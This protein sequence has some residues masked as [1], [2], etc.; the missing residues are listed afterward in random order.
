VGKCPSNFSLFQRFLNPFPVLRR[1]AAIPSPALG[2]QGTLLAGNTK[3]DS[4]ISFVMSI[5]ALLKSQDSFILF[6]PKKEH[7]GFPH[8]KLTIYFCF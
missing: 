8:H 3:Y 7:A 6:F 1:G 4:M 5:Q 2:L